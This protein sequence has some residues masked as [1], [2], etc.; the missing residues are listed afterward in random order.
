MKKYLFCLLSVMTFFSAFAQKEP[1]EGYILY[2]YNYFDLEG[3]DI[4]SKMLLENDSVQHYYINKS[5]YI[6]YKQNQTLEQ[7][8]N[9][10]TNKYYY[11]RD[12]KI[13][14]LDAG[15]AQSPKPK[16]KKLDEKKTILGH[17]CTA[18]QEIIE[19]NLVINYISDDIWVDPAPYQ[20]H[21]LG[22][23]G[24]FL[25]ESK[26]RLGLQITSFHEDYYVT[27]TAVLIQNLVL[28][29]EAFD[30]DKLLKK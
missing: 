5:N 6:S 2:R 27:M 21:K 10:K 18:I 29:A 9:S 8:Y 16:Y 15:K 24:E 19:T 3:N 23:W 17:K 30:I 4:S 13:Y 14:V 1:F 28:P 11:A 20:N 25:K 26:G 22:N 12:S 7:L